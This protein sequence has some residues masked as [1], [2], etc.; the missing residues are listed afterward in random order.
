ME[1]K[2]I[3]Q[4][5]D[6]NL[7]FFVDSVTFLYGYPPMQD[8]PSAL[9]LLKAMVTLLGLASLPAWAN[10]PEEEIVVEQVR[11][12]TIGSHPDWPQI[13]VVFSVREESATGASATLAL[14][15]AW[16]GSSGRPVFAGGSA[17]FLIPPPGRNHRL[18]F[19]I[20]PS[21]GRR[22]GSV[23][24]PLA[25][26]VEI[27]VEGKRLRPAEAHFHG[28]A[29]LGRRQRFMAEAARSKP[30]AIIWNWRQAHPYLPPSEGIEPGEPL[31]P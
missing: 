19:F 13:T 24:Q 15:A 14:T 2:S 20:H 18:H 9:C 31:L 8:S 11:F 29:D 25:W 30:A 17:S 4:P 12:S 21:L 5:I 28:L 3:R 27:E 23:G 26:A 22:H 10:S 6:R 16:N 1:E 7:T